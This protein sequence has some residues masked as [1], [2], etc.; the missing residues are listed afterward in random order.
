MRLGKR[1]QAVS[2]LKPGDRRAGK[3]Q[4]WL[5]PAA[6]VAHSLFPTRPPATCPLRAHGSE[7]EITAEAVTA[8]VTGKVSARFRGEV[9]LWVT[10]RSLRRHGKCH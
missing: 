7:E 9:T 1:K 8:G 10:I 2:D 6:G 3:R 5:C 4:R